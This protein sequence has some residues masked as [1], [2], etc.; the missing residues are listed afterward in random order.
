MGSTGFRIALQLWSIREECAGDLEKALKAVAGMGFEGVEFAGFHG[1]SARDLRRLLEALGL[2]AVGAHIPYRDLAGPSG[3]DTIEYCYELGLRYTI[4]PSAPPEIRSSVS[5]WASLAS[6]LNSLSERLSERGLR[7]GYHNHDYEFRSVEG[8]V[9]WILLSRQT[10][11]SVIMQL[12]TANALAGGVEPAGLLELVR[13]LE[14]RLLSVHV[15][16]YSR[17]LGRQTILG[18]GD[19]PWRDLLRLL[20]TRGGTEWLVLEQEHYPRSPLE[21][22]RMSLENLLRILESV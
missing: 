22:V 18:E 14:G 15:K 21:S 12:D 6:L 2:E 17:S 7:A 20:R 11:R 5:G 3:G 4:I 13:S 10:R 16:D 1:R 8:I 9:P 19:V